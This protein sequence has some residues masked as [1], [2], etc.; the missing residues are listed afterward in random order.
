M[1]A[2]KAAMAERAR[3]GK[4]LTD[5]DIDAIVGI[6]DGWTSKL[7]WPL[8]LDAVAAKLHS[9]YT[10]Q[11]LHAHERIRAAFALRKSKRDSGAGRKPAAT[12]EL[13][14]A[15][16]K[17]ER[18]EATVERLEMENGLLLQQFVTW[19]YNAHTRGLTKEFLNR[20]LPAVDRNATTK[21]ESPKR[22]KE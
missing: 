7:T 6:L 21:T 5:T 13:E 8:L 11:T 4:N 17:I 16:Q 19:A 15:M 9:S 20:P 18:L 10:R 14:A 3:R 1:N 12:P 2:R 22:C